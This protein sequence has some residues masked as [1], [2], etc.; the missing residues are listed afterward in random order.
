MAANDGERAKKLT[1]AIIKN[2]YRV[3]MSR[4]MKGCFVYAVDPG[5]RDRLKRFSRK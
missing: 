4:G 2:T 1:D 3:L 5:V